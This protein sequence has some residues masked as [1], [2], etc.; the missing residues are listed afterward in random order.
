MSAA[1]APRAAALRRRVRVL[2]VAT[3]DANHRAMRA[4]FNPITCHSFHAVDDQVFVATTR[5]ERA[6]AGE[7]SPPQ[8][9]ARHGLA[10]GAA[11]NRAGIRPG[12]L[13][14]A[15]RGLL[16]RRRR[17]RGLHARDGFLPKDSSHRS[18]A[19]IQRRAA[20]ERSLERSPVSVSAR[21]H[22]RARRR[23]RASGG[24]RSPRRRRR[25]RFI[26]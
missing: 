20:R 26:L 9:S 12:F 24:A 4:C 2:S 13:R 15:R 23:A 8:T 19:T 7:A 25:R 10:R 5:A 11:S 6:S 3:R 14:Q 1:T 22:R 17:V 16:R 18:R 21:A